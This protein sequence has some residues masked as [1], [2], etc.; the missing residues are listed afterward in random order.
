[1]R[2]EDKYREIRVKICKLFHN[3]YDAFGYRKIYI[4]FKREGITLFQKVIRRIMQEEGLIVKVHRRRK[5]NSYKGEI[6][7]HGKQSYQQELPC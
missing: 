4:L 5:Y 6:S 1:M 3:N 2:A 7:P